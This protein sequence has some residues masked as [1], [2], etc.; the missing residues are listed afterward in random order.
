M[1]VYKNLPDIVTKISELE[2]AIE[3][4]RLKMSN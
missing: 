4:L 1:A 3:E 2:K